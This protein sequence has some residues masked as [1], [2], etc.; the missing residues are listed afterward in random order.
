MPLQAACCWQLRPQNLTAQRLD[1]PHCPTPPTA[2]LCNSTADQA[3]VAQLEAQLTAQAGSDVTIYCVDTPI[4]GRRLLATQAIV[5]GSACR[6][7]NL[8]LPP[9]VEQTGES[10]DGCVP[11][12]APAQA[13]PVSAPSFLTE[14]R[15]HVHPSA[16]RVQRQRLV[17]RGRPAAVP[18]AHSQHSP[19]PAPLPTC[20]PPLRSARLW[21]AS[22]RDHSP[23]ARIPAAIRTSAFS[24]PERP[25]YVGCDHWDVAVVSFALT[26]EGQFSFIAC[27]H[28]MCEVMALSRW[29]TP[30][31]HSPAP[32]PTCS[33]PLVRAEQLIISAQSG[34]GL[35][36]CCSPLFCEQNL[37]CVISARGLA[38][39]R[40]RS[41]PMPRFSLHTHTRLRRDRPSAHPAVV[42][43][44]KTRPPVPSLPAHRPGEAICRA[45]RTYGTLP[46]WRIPRSSTALHAASY[47]E[48]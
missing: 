6:I 1:P 42:H 29:L 47:V 48:M 17:L 43:W 38:P 10:A 8:A 44:G 21:M 16:S 9:G 31:T 34:C 46:I 41:G 3:A 27:V 23:P 15:A 13:S 7:K 26:T 2:G 30:N 25:A 40:R 37:T 36:G 18:L 20:S 45:H 4:T 12:V 35:F 24:P 32:P 11:V 22:V 19:S 33:P 5:T 28:W 14:Q 39:N